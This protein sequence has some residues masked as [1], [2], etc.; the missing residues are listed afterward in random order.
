MSQE[1][2]NLLFTVVLLPLITALSG[3]V[4]ALLR[5][6]SAEIAEKIESATMQKYITLATDIVAQ[7]VDYTAQTYVK[8][9]RAKN[10]FGKVAQKEAFGRAKETALSLLSEPVKE[11]VESAFGD[12]ETWIGTRIEQEV[13]KSG[14]RT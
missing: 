10:S 14:S 5:K 2:I 9:L 12:L 8:E 7:A 13:Y 3:F 6:K 1:N 11:A 4:I